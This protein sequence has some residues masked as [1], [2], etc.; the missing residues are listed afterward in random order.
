MLRTHTAGSLRAEQ[1]GDHVT[2]TGW[3]ASRRD[4][5]GVEFIDLRD[6]SGIVQV[7]ARDEVLTGAAHGLRNEYCVKVTGEVTRRT[8]ENVNPD[9]PTGEVEVVAAD[10]EV[11]SESAP[12]PFQIDERIDRRRGGAAEVPLSRPAAPR[13]AQRRA[14]DPV[15][16]EGLSGRAAGARRAGLRRDRDARR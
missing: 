11:L 15:A 9:L 2:L 4:H 8:P 13:R 10:I 6:A 14:C 16:V 5:G 1:A 7:V 12:L 3:V